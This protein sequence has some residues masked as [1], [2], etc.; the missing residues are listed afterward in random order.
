MFL[1]LKLSELYP[2]GVFVIDIWSLQQTMIPK[3][4]F[5]RQFRTSNGYVLDLNLFFILSLVSHNGLFGL[6]HRVCV[7]S[8]AGAISFEWDETC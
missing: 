4:R 5:Y 3:G 1:S 2:Y 8:Q 7:P 6:G